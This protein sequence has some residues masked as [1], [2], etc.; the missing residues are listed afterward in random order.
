MR[1]KWV[2]I[3]ATTLGSLLFWA[4]MAMAQLLIVLNEPKM[5]GKETVSQCV[6]EG[7]KFAFAYP[8]GIVRVLSTEEMHLTMNFNPRIAQMKAFGLEY[9]GQG[10]KIPPLP[11][12]AEE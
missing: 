1:S 10:E 9:A 5:N 11:R 7:D 3:V 8:N 4:A 2:I 12:S 6:N